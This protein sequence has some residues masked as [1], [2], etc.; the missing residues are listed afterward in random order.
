M[1]RRVLK[2]PVLSSRAKAVS[3]YSATSSARSRKLMPPMR[4]GVPRKALPRIG[5][6]VRVRD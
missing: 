1:T 6:G 3:W 2:A 4:E 5:V